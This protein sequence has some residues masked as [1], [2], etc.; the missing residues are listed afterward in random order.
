[1]TFNIDAPNIP[2]GLTLITDEVSSLRSKDEYRLGAVVDT[3]IDGREASKVSFDKV[4]FA[5]VTVTESTLNGVE[6]TDV[7][8]DKCDFSNVGFTYSFF[9]CAELRNCKCIATD[10]TRSRFRHVLF[11]AASAITPHSASPPSSG[12]LL[13]A[14]P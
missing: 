11:S 4:A 1:M 2:D 5:N 13:K 12:F 9:H 6:A 8:F 10:F 14:I 3:V 7:A